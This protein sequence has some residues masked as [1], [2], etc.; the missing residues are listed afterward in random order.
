MAKHL[1]AVVRIDV[2]KCGSHRMAITWQVMKIE[3]LR[4]GAIEL[5]NG[6]SESEYK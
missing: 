5:G 2:A 6:C 3:I 4:F 1:A